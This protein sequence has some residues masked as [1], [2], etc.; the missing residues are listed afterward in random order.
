MFFIGIFGIESKE[1]KIK[2][3][4]NFFCK[5]CNKEETGQLIK[6]YNYFHIFFVPVLKWNENYYVLCNYCS[7]VYEIAKEKGKRLERGE[8]ENITYWDLKEIKKTNGVRICKNC[9]SQVEDRFVYCPYC[10]N[11][12]E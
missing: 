10:G 4:P 11:R 8:G 12:L 5:G 1:K 3:L 6:T 7:T 9:N 2:E